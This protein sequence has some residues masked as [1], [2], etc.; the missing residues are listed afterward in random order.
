MIGLGLSQRQ[1]LARGVTE[2]FAPGNLVIGVLL[3]TGWNST[4]PSPTGIG[5]GALAAAFCGILPYS[6]LIYGSR[7]RWWTDRHVRLRRQR[8]I[9][10][11]A[12]LGSVCVGVGLLVVLGAPRQLLVLVLAMLAGL[13][14][15]L[16]ITA[17]WKVSVHT[18]VAAGTVVVLAEVFTP[19][20]ALGAVVVALIGWSRVCL[21]DHTT[22]QVI[23]G[24]VVGAAVAGAVF[25]PLT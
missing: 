20:A 21:A 14:V 2:V 19:V 8:A 17:V 11:V 25:I 1:L 4:W 13:L 5:W 23:G 6:L 18:A 9:P 24:A 22:V 16:A 7:H 12:T 15:S 3:V 10:L